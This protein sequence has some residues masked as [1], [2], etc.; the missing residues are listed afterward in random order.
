MQVD[1]VIKILNIM[2]EW[3]PAYGELVER[4]EDFMN[5]I[6]HKASYVSDKDIEKLNKKIEIYDEI[7]NPTVLGAKRK[8][9][10]D[11]LEGKIAFLLVNYRK[12]IG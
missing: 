7:V 1:S 4:L 3:D 11:S 12:N 10:E 8:Y 6:K 5:E 2:E 9:F